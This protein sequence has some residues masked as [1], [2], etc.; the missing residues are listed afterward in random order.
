VPGL[1]SAGHLTVEFLKLQAKAEVPTLPYRGAGPALN[2]LPGGHIPLL[3]HP[4]L[5]ALP[6][7]LSGKPQAPAVH[8]PQAWAV[9]S[10][11]VLSAVDGEIQE[12]PSI[13]AGA[14]PT[15]FPGA[16]CFGVEGI[17]GIPRE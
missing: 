7:V 6:K 9:R 8:P 2:D 12:Q 10:A 1:G 11:H 17:S 4:M 15:A 14:G 16:G 5:S 13:G 3:A